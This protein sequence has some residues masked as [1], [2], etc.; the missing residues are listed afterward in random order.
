[1]DA[2]EIKLVTTPGYPEVFPFASK[3]VYYLG[4]PLFGRTFPPET[5]D[6]EIFLWA[7]EEI[8]KLEW[9]R[10]E[11]EA[12]I[13]EKKREAQK[14]E[15]E[16]EKKRNIER[17]KALEILR[18]RL[19][20][21]NINGCGVCDDAKVVEAARLLRSGWIDKFFFMVSA[22]GGIVRWYGRESK[23]L[24]EFARRKRQR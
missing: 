15:E 11:E 1:M 24:P 2:I 18:H 13:A 7:A 6:E 5:E 22:G 23:Y 8:K 16:E 14:E 3:M 9:K 19:M 20:K 10:N 17:K 21:E 4:K 12:L